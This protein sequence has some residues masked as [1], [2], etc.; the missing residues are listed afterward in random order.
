[1]EPAV[2][3][4]SLDHNSAESLTPLN[5]IN[6]QISQQISVNDKITLECETVGQGWMF[7]E[8]NRS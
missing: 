7:D 1:M 5:K 8:R 3:M 2:S 6:R 4:T